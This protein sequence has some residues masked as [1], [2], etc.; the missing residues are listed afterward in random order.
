MT[1]GLFALLGVIIG[2]LINNYISLQTFRRQEIVQRQQAVRSKMIETYEF[3][4]TKL[5]EPPRSAEKLWDTWA[6]AIRLKMYIPKQHFD[7][8]NFF[9]LK[10]A[11]IPIYTEG[12]KPIIPP[13][14]LEGWTPKYDELVIVIRNELDNVLTEQFQSEEFW[15]ESIFK[16]LIATLRKMFSKKGQAPN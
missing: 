14:L 6:A 13:E 16:K 4:L 15:C 11:R 1:N 5:T 9:D 8:V 10:G 12:A 3:A 2:G 7:L